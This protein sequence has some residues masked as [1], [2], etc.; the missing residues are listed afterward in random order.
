MFN[1]FDSIC[2]KNGELIKFSNAG[3]TLLDFGFIHCDATYDVIP[4]KNN[5]FIGLDLHLKRLKNSCDYFN[6]DLPDI[7]YIVIMQQLLHTNGLDDAFVWIAVW[8][9]FPKSGNPRDIKSCPINYVIYVKPYYGI[10]SN[11]LVKLN[12]ETS[13]RRVGNE[14]FDQQCKN[15]SWIEFSKSQFHLDF[16]KE[17]ALLLDSQGYVTEGPGFNVGF[18]VKDIILTPKNNCLRG[19]TI[20]LLEQICKDKNLKF[21]Y[22]NITVDQALNSDAVFISS[23]SGGIT[24]AYITSNQQDSNQILT[25]LIS[26]YNTKYD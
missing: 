3:P 17:S 24:P 7:D 2:Y 14:H 12:L 11:N 5:K 8:R 1:I 21:E 15:F 13:N 9:G 26:L 4:V 20:Q 19:V 16:T 25:E 6:L 18:V 22:E 23:S 10:N